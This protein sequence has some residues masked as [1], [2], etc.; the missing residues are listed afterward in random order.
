M[1]PQAM[2]MPSSM[3]RLFLI[4]TLPLLLLTACRRGG[5]VK[6]QGVP[7]SYQ[8]RKHAEGNHFDYTGNLSKSLGGS[9]EAT[10]NL[11][12]FSASIDSANAGEHGRILSTIMQAKGDSAF[13]RYVNRL[14]AQARRSI[15]SQLAS[16]GTDP[17]PQTARALLPAP[18]SR[19]FRGL[20]ALTPEFAWFRDCTLSQERFIA[21]DQT[22][23]AE[24]KYRQILRSPYHGQAVYVHLKGYHAPYYADRSLPPGYA[25]FLV[26]TEIM[27]LEAKNFRNTCIPYDF[28]AIGN[29]PFWQVQISANEGLI[30]FK[31]IDDE[32]MKAF[33]FQTPFQTDGEQV[34]AAVNPETGDN[35]RVAIS[36][37]P[38][39]D[40]MSDRRYPFSANLTFN[41]R[42]YKGCA[43]EFDAGNTRE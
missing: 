41:G 21:V 16:T 2:K 24:K 15:W 37:K 27:A 30:E 36:S 31:S 23:E 9:E 28:W 34:F 39:S 26:I 40:G 33:S 13:A 43:Q 17:L 5:P 10:E 20:Y 1:V 3:P 4:A 18:G 29:E 35:I 25:G 22:G 19:E 12:A 6:V 32:K 14:S 38:C 11:L 7:V 42:S 8:L